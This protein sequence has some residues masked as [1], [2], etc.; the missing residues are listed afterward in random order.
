MRL[1]EHSYK[2]K[3]GRFNPAAPLYRYEATRIVEAITGEVSE[4]TDGIYYVLRLPN[5]W[6]LYPI[7]FDSFDSMDHKE[8]WVEEISVLL[9]TEWGKKLQESARELRAKLL[10]H[11]T[12]FPRGR[13]LYLGKYVVWH[14]DN[15][16]EQMPHIEQ[17]TK[18]FSLPSDAKL[19]VNSHEMC[20]A[21][22]RDAIR[23]VLKLDETWKAV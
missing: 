1:L 18:A 21:S 17:I 10:G 15:L 6:T 11:Y 9:A 3:P 23:H 8:L 14:G 5:R 12:G 19:E 22:S 16:A 20:L 7:R 4:P 2:T 13:V